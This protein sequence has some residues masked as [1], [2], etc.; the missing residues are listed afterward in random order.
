MNS[1]PKSKKEHSRPPLSLGLPLES[2]SDSSETIKVNENGNKSS[3][4]TFLV[5]D[6]ISDSETLLLDNGESNSET[7]Q[8]NTTTGKSI[9]RKKL[10]G[11]R[12]FSKNSLNHC[13]SS[14]ATFIDGG[15][16]QWSRK[17]N[18]NE[19]NDDKTFSETLPIDQSSDLTGDESQT[20]L[21]D[22]NKSKEFVSRGQRITDSKLFDKIKERY[23]RST[24]SS[25][26]D[27]TPR[28]KRPKRII[29]DP[30]FADQQTTPIS[31]YPDVILQSLTSTE[32]TKLESKQSSLEHSKQ[33][34]NAE[35]SEDKVESING[36]VDT[37]KEQIPSQDDLKKTEEDKQTEE[38][39]DVDSVDKEGE[40]CRHDYENVRNVEE[41]S[42]SDIIKSP[43]R[44]LKRSRCRDQPLINDQHIY[45]EVIPCT[46]EIVQHQAEPVAEHIYDELKKPEKS[47]F[48]LQVKSSFFRLYAAVTPWWVA[49]KV[50]WRNEKIKKEE[51]RLFETSRRNSRI[52]AKKDL[53]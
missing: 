7:L 47:N 11:E 36:I 53:F 45:E 1:S 41:D 46:H 3:S 44:R 16:H 6:N 38:K 20:L 23:E 12:S 29:R 17:N 4:E 50:F 32:R 39:V 40:K 22:E 13:E 21:L 10:K 2:V 28:E 51:T 35:K 26:R 9:L 37:R 34:E 48:F 19:D 18:S 5:E 14:S 49:R 8:V 25:S 30:P 52:K 31:R 33:Q 15:S 43:R 27:E 42:S 24:A